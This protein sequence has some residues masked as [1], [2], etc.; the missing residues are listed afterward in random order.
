[1]TL[2]SSEVKQ[3]LRLPQ[4]PKGLVIEIVEYEFH[5]SLRLYRD[6]FERF[7]GTDKRHIAGLV[8]ETINRIRGIGV[9][10]YLEVEKGD[11]SVLSGSNLVD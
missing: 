4:W 9:P 1:M 5:I 11:G 8:G 10:C 2:V 3:I 6:N 7:D